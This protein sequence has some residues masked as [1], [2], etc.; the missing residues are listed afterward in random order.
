M[1]MTH[2]A[3]ALPWEGA[4][5]YIFA[6]GRGHIRAWEQTAAVAGGMP[7][8]PSAGYF[9]CGF[10]R[11]CY[12]A[13]SALFRAGGVIRI[14][15]AREAS[16]YRGDISLVPC[17]FPFSFSSLASLPFGKVDAAYLIPK[18]FGA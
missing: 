1:D 16:P 2:L 5:A 8:G 10:T 4:C 6:L 11:F 14:A 9:L 7:F 15:F 3:H 12:S 17:C 18:S 13:G